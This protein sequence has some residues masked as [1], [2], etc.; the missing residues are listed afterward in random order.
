MTRARQ[1]PGRSAL[2]TGAHVLSVVTF[3]KS[4]QSWLPNDAGGVAKL[5]A[6]CSSRD[7]ISATR[8]DK[9][10]GGDVHETNREQFGCVEPGTDDSS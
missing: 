3:L 10:D 8:Q 2:Y 5:D 6:R 7:A 1:S 9:F 4:C